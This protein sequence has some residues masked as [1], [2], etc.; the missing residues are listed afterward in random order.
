MIL[1]TIGGFMRTFLLKAKHF[2]KRNIYPITV[3]MC[4]VLV[5]G[6]ITV[7]AY[8]S[9]KKSNQVVVD[10]NNPNIS[11]SDRPADNVDDEV[12]TGGPAEDIDPEPSKPVVVS[13][14]FDLPFEN[15]KI[16]KNYTDSTLVYDKTTD[17]WCTHQAIDFSCS[18][19]QQVKAVFDGVIS[20]IESSMMYGTIVHLKVSS[21]LVVVY[22]GLMSDVQVKEGDEVKKGTVI[23]KVTSFLAEKADGVHLHLELFM[24]EKL[25]DPNKYF[26]INK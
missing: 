10:V 8:T 3:T 14:V 20:K 24:G 22:K 6:I 18:E 23:G 15:A 4:T 9:I 21:D 26:S 1:V 5:L 2:F 7:S 12:Q 11:D 16:L 25:I 17:L 19:G 13:I